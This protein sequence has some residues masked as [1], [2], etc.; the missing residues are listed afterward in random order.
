LADDS[1]KSGGVTPASRPAQLDLPFGSPPEHAEFFDILRQLEAG[2]LQPDRARM[3]IMALYQTSLGAWVRALAES[4]PAVASDVTQRLLRDMMQIAR[5]IAADTQQA[6]QQTV[7]RLVTLST[8][9]RLKGKAVD[10]LQREA[11]LLQALLSTNQ[12]VPLHELH[13]LAVKAE[14]DLTAAA[15]TANLDRLVK[16]L[17]IG[18]PRKGQYAS[19]QAS[20]AYL[21]AL[22][23]ELD[24]RPGA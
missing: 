13:T 2:T 6:T 4:N 19:T 11:R 15:L 3:R 9:Q 5:D 23:S 16:D 7:P 17:V 1:D 14:P 22:R 24:A 21:G 12:T 10:V 20:K 8:D 18:K